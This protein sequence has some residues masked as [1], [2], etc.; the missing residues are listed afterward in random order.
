[1]NIQF[2]DEQKGALTA[3][4]SFMQDDEQL[5]FLLEGYAGT[6]KTTCIQELVKTLGV[7]TALTAPTNKATRVL[8]EMARKARGDDENAAKVVCGTIYS[9]LGLL[10][11][12]DAE[13][14]RIVPEGESKIELYKLIVVDEAS[15]VSEEL[16][17]HILEQ[18]QNHHKKVIFMGD[19]AQLPP[20]NEIRSPV[21]DLITNKATLTKVMRHDNQILNLATAVRKAWA[22]GTETRNLVKT[23]N[24]ELG[25]V[26]CVDSKKFAAQ[27]N[28][29]FT[30]DTYQDDP[31][32][33]RI[34]AW[35]N[36]AVN[37]YNS[38]VRQL[39]YGDD[40]QA[41]HMGER[42]VVCQPIIDVEVKAKTKQTEITMTTDSEA[43]V[44]KMEEVNHP[45]YKRFL[46]NRLVL[47]D[48]EGWAS[49][50][51]VIHP[52]MAAEMKQTLSNIADDAKAR[53]GS[54]S[55][56]WEMKGLFHDVRPC[57]A[58]TAHRSQ[59]STYDTVLVDVNNIMLNRRE[60]EMLQCL[61][62]AVSRASRI[63]V[64]R[65]R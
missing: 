63:V 18:A 25:G 4:E 60:K 13:K 42:V 24:D 61:Y 14:Q 56:F 30:A 29:A 47:E 35:T 26:W 43:V 31:S 28:A 57:H 1:M 36:E 37:G 2:N 17:N 6:G 5:F 48:D 20:V 15:M 10:L 54:W 46:C 32:K 49:E 23:D 8:M 51:Y 9:I 53:R 55:S 59:G 19:P 22:D 39:I 52:S 58:I 21:F 27:I 50:V 40:T 34:I 62:V 3:M 38:M 7:E 44:I 64:A 16:F 33:V 12:G 41:F 65:T 11:K 45:V